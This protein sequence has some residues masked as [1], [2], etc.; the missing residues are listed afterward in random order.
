[1]SQRR[2]VWT[3]PRQCGITSGALMS[4]GGHFGTWKQC[5]H[6][7]TLLQLGVWL[8]YPNL[9]PGLVSLSK[10]LSL[11]LHLWPWLKVH[12]SQL[13]CVQHCREEWGVGKHKLPDSCVKEWLYTWGF[14]A[15]HNWNTLD[16]QLS[17]L[18]P[19][20]LESS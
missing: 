9:L 19:C 20:V 6:V 8:N 14:L 7:S 2:T 3:C 12:C 13:C 4:T 5:S 16:G 11:Q 15:W 1:M 18:K 10:S 17:S